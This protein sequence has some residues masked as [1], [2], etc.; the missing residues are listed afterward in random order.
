[1]DG[2]TTRWQS[3]QVVGE[4]LTWLWQTTPTIIVATAAMSMT[5]TITRQ[6]LVWPNMLEAGFEVSKCLG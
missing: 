3:G 5:V 1:M 2:A 4:Q 6:I